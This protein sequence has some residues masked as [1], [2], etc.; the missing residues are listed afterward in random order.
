M[1]ER[2]I[3]HIDANHAELVSRFVRFVLPTMTQESIA[4]FDHA[5]R[6]GMD[7]YELMR[8]CLLGKNQDD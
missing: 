7:R 4:G 6:M 1:S 3:Q 5:V 2:S 8:L